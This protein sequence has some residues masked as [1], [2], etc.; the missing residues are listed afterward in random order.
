MW[1][2]LL[3]VKHVHPAQGLG[4]AY[5]SQVHLRRF[6]IDPDVEVLALGMVSV[7]SLGRKATKS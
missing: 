5:P 7:A 2:P 6:E 3:P 1:F 4:F